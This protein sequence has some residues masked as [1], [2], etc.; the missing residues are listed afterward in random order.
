[1]D[2]KIKNNIFP[3]R[4]CNF[5]YINSFDRKYDNTKQKI[6]LVTFPISR[7]NKYDHTITF[8]KARTE[9]AAI[10]VAEQFLSEPLTKEY[11]NKI[12]SDTFHQYSWKDA[13]K[14]FQCKGDVLTDLRFL[15]NVML[16]ENGNAT[17]DLGS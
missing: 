7:Y 17:L 5:L 13:Q 10:H 3:R 16:D 11:Y 8:D 4:G 2:K 12:K 6:R 1:M 15:E 9:K 14:F